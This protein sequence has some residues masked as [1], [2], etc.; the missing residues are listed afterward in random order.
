M[1][2]ANIVGQQAVKK[3]LIQAVKEQRISHA[4]LF[5]GPQGSGSLP[6]AIAYA[7]YIA[8]ENKQSEDSCGQCPSCIKY[9][10]L[11]HPDLHFVFPLALLK[12][13]KTSSDKIREWRELVLRN[14]YITLFEWIENL[15]AENKQA[16]IGGEESAEIL[17][18]LNLTS[19]ETGY[20][21]VII[22]YPEKMNP[23][24]ANKLLKILE[25]PP[26]K[27]LFILVCENEDQLL[28]TITSRTQIVKIPK[29]KDEDLIKDLCEKYN[30]NMESAQT[31][32]NLAD[33]NYSEA[34]LLVSEN[35]NT[36]QNLLYFQKF[37]RAS[38]KFDTK[39]VLAWIDDISKAGRERQKNFISY[40]LHVIRESLIL[41]SNATTLKKLT[42]SPRHIYSNF[43]AKTI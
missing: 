32:T 24:A 2:F 21:T 16:I 25:E 10:K 11:V 9:Q 13:I 18:K 34:L 43:K 35:E 3:R 39:A 5:L 20:K 26:A 15:Q 22:W 19:Y 14:P 6:L 29:I 36:E 28:R 30:L 40:A 17:R 27:T 37:M 41:N 7:C 31:I 1:L 8:C 23:T 4:Q 42:D 38:L 33:G 12:D